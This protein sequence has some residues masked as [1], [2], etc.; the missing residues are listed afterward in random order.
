MAFTYIGINSHIPIYS[1]LSTDTKG[2]GDKGAILYE[3]NVG[4]GVRKIYQT[5]DGE[6][7]IDIS[8]DSLGV[9]GLEAG[10]NLIGKFGIDQTTAN[11]NEVVVKSITAG[12]NLLG[13]VGI[14]QTTPGTTNGVVIN[15]NLA[16]V[17]GIKTVT[18][19][20]TRVQLSATSVPVKSVLIT[21]LHTNTGLIYIGTIAVSSSAYGKRLRAEESITIPV[22]DLNLIYLDASVSGEGVSFLGVN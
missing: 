11:A 22:S 2:N 5:Y 10:N 3:F 6:N 19:A 16:M 4:T 17:Q 14:D 1:C 21:A 7:W 8:N 15:G 13:K 20:T 12:A 18:T 9:V